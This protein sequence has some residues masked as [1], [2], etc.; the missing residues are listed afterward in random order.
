MVCVILCACV[1]V[2]LGGLKIQVRIVTQSSSELHEVPLGS[3]VIIQP[4]RERAGMLS[5]GF[6]EGS[7]VRLLQRHQ[8]PKPPQTVTRA[9]TAIAQVRRAACGPSTTFSTTRS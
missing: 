8:T 7:H 2:C 3:T 5:A 4:R 6:R 1:C 9:A